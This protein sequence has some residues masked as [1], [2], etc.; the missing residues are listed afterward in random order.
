MRYDQNDDSTHQ[1]QD[2]HLTTL[3]RLLE[4]PATEL[5]PT[6]NRAAQLV[7]EVL[8]ADKVDLFFYDPTI[9]TLMSMGI[10]DTPMGRHQQ[11]IGMD[12]L[13][14]A[15]G[16]RIVEVFLHG[17]AYITGHAD[18]DPDELIGI[19]SGLGVVSEIATVFQVQAK[20][21]GVLVVA[22]A[23]PEFFSQ[24]DLHF[25]EAVA[26]WLGIVIDRAELV[27]QV[28]KD[29][30]A[31]GRRLAAEELL[32]VM[33]HDLR[34]Y[35]TPLHGRLWLLER[36]AQRDGRKQDIRD[37]QASRHTLGLLEHVIV[38]LLDVARLNQGLFAIT[39]QPM[40]LVD[41]VL[42]VVEAFRT[43]ETTI[44]V[45]VPEEVVLCA[46]P[47]RLRQVIENLLAN[48]VK[49][50][51]RDTPIS[52]EV[53]TEQRA[54]CSWVLLSIYNQGSGLPDESLEALFQPFVTG[55]QSI[56]L[57]LGLYLARKI[58]EAHAGTLTIA[59]PESKGV[60]VVLSLP[61]EQE[62]DECS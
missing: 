29:A 3:E 7:A 41:L 51:P 2:R 40:N 50:A 53:H 62:S 43:T 27:E 57:G 60:Q 19:K 37:V 22:S 14:I 21:R 47:D 46:D 39:P 61:L 25:L 16:G 13:P 42:E 45:Q 17:T 5:D 8:S 31:Q 59:S 58:A 28:R 36:R 49:Y 32:T 6:L 48:A 11:A 33:A 26:R 44:D 30:V 35:L 52:V 9:E 23:T 15:N 4:L 56:G 34:N 54:E 55:S 1:R 38:D 12:R 20:H 24:H 10:S 18:Q